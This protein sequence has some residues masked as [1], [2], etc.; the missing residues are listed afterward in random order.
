MSNK[1][2]K[3][4]KFLLEV[5]KMK[6]ILRQT[7]KL[8]DRSREDDAEHSWHFALMAFV[9]SEYASESV[10]TVS[11]THLAA[12]YAAKILEEGIE[13]CDDIKLAS[14][15]DLQIKSI[16]AD[17]KRCVTDGDI[18]TAAAAAR[19]NFIEE[20]CSAAVKK[21][22][23]YST[24][25]SDKADKLFTHRVLGIPIF[26]VIMALIFSLT[27]SSSMFGLP[28]P[29]ALLH[30]AVAVSYTHLDVYKRQ[31]IYMAKFLRIP[32]MYC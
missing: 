7:L 3:Q 26:A 28:M 27:F 1:L 22:K 4:V 24:T 2:E 11:Y 14:A 25:A 19:Y 12:Y 6:N 15:A 5:D 32:K 13:A 10:D 16:Y 21:S 8:T 29:G 18:E 30:S 23:I 20:C 17:A 31:M 9:L